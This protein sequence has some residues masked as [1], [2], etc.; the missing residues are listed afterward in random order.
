MKWALVMESSVHGYYVSEIRDAEQKPL[1]HPSHIRHW[2]WIKIPPSED[3][4]V[5]DIW[6]GES[7]HSPQVGPH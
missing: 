5:G 2:R 6:S 7:F 1:Y 4:R 3:V